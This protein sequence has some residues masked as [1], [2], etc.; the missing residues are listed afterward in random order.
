MDTFI[1]ITVGAITTS[2]GLG[3]IAWIVKYL[4]NPPNRRSLIKTRIQRIFWVF[5][6]IWLT[7]FTYTILDYASDEE[8]FTYLIFSPISLFCSYKIFQWIRAGE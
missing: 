6:I 3:I 2:I 5:T 7:F 1:I 4:K 8:I